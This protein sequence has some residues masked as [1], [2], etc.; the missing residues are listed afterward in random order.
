[1]QSRI[2]LTHRAEADIMV[3][4]DRPELWGGPVEDERFLVVSR[5]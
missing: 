3:L 1:M 4:S 5:R 2:V